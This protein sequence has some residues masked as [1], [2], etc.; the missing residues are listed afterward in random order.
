MT[1]LA[2]QK[3]QG[4]ATGMKVT[5][6]VGAIATLVSIV[7]NVLGV[8]MAGMEGGD[9]GMAGMMSGGVGIAVGVIGLA[10]AVFLWIVAGKM[11]RLQD[12][13]LCLVGAIA[14]MVPCISPCCFIGLPIGIWAVVVMAKPEVK[15]AFASSSGSV[16]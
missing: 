16:M 9:E 7:M 10:V 6:V 15:E 8:G 5:A 2:R 12:Y 11:E 1:E 14:A 3:M 13:N 4:P